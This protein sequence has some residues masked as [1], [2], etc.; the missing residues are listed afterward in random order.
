[1]RIGSSSEQTL[2]SAQ[3]RPRALC[4]IAADSG[5]LQ[6]LPVRD[7]VTR[8]HGYAEGITWRDIPSVALGLLRNLQAVSTA[9][10]DARTDANC[11]RS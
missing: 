11:D 2:L 8:L 4:A 1:M 6:T 5:T 9:H 10:G 3:I 7:N